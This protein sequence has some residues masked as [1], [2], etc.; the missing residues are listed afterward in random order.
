MPESSPQTTGWLDPILEL[1][2]QAILGRLSAGLVHAMNNVLGGVLGQVDLLLLSRKEPQ[3]KDDLE[4]IAQTCE[5]GVILTKSLTRVISTLRSGAPADSRG[6]LEA[7]LVLLS[8]IHK[9]AGVEHELEN[10]GRVN[11]VG[12][13]RCFTQASFH[14][15]LAAFEALSADGIPSRR[16]KSRLIEGDGKVILELI[17]SSEL[18]SCGP[19]DEKEMQSVPSVSESRYHAWV[20][21]HLCAAGGGSW[22]VEDERQSVRLVW[23]VA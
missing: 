12:D 20:L 7:L 9:R 17:A 21:G 3:L 5:Q 19:L 8:R 13:G 2:R 1:D 11:F 22:E 23:P 6:V 18:I 10:V 15:M 16:M 14:L 4:Q